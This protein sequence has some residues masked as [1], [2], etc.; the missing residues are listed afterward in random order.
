M[1]KTIVLF[2]VLISLNTLA[3][4]QCADLFNNNKKTTVVLSTAELNDLTIEI[5]TYIKNYDLPRILNGDLKPNWNHYNTLLTFI[6][7]TENLD[8]AQRAKIGVNLKFTSQVINESIKNKIANFMSKDKTHKLFNRFLDYNIAYFKLL[9]QLNRNLKAEIIP[10][11][12]FKELPTEQL[13]IDEAKKIIKNLEK[14]TD[15]NFTEETGFKD[16]EDL[17][18]KMIKFNPQLNDLIDLV[19]NNLIVTMR[20]PESGRFWIPITGFQNQRITESSR[21]TLY[22]DSTKDEISGRDQAESHLTK[23]SVEDYVPLSGR[24]KPNYAEARPSFTAE[25]IS[26]HS[27]ASQYGSDLWVIKKSILESRATWTPSDS[28][29]PGRKKWSDLFIPW[30]ERILM[31]LY[32][33][34]S[35]SN[36]IFATLSIPQEFS[37]KEPFNWESDTR[38]FEVQIYGP[39]SINDV[40]AF[41]FTENP[42]DKKL[43][44]LLKSKG[45]KVF[46][47][48]NNQNKEYFGEDSP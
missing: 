18:N 47:T 5:D 7:K 43:Y 21:G 25:N 28:L 48:R 11:P 23:I 41:H 4:N 24:L 2:I 6:Q 26:F 33:M 35:F 29:G 44:Q 32:A 14:E 31:S 36:R 37:Q 22:D 17:K 46:D 27:E 16:R 12:S 3:A 34:S 13:L 39:L 8:H 20:R 19:E 38:Y 40:E 10:I 9:E 42:P 30:K 1:I 15:Q 45:I